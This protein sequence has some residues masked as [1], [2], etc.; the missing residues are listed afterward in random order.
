MKDIMINTKPMTYD[1]LVRVLGDMPNLKIDFYNIQ[2]LLGFFEETDGIY[3][4][5]CMYH[6]PVDGY[7]LLNM[8]LAHHI[9]AV[10]LTEPLTFDIQHVSEYIRY[11]NPKCQIRFRPYIGREAWAPVN[12]DICHFWVL[13]QHLHFYE[14]YVDV[15]DILATETLREETLYEIYKRGSYTLD[16]NALIEHFDIDPPM[17]AY[18]IDDAI[19]L[20]R[21]NC[22]QVCQSSKPKRC[23]ICDVQR[24][25]VKYLPIAARQHATP[26]QS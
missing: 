1:L 13:P 21:L 7:N 16:M 23:H 15:I 10:T 2:D 20:R 25:M 17:T 9:G 8:L 5:R 18:W 24:M 26:S 3:N 19:A 6:Y 22:K 11:D 12:D 14:D 4:E